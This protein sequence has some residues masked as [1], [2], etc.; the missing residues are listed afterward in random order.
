M[1]NA[2][3][4]LKRIEIVV[5]PAVTEVTQPPSNVPTLFRILNTFSFKK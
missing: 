3:K 4:G 1:A 2:T 5:H